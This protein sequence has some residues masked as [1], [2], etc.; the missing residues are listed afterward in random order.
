MERGAAV[1]G[2]NSSSQMLMMNAARGGNLD[3]VRYV[4][5]HGA[6]SNLVFTTDDFARSP[7]CPISALIFSTPRSEKS[8]GGL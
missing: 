2:S 6:N 4:V 3:V 5:E 1:N 7:R 8:Y